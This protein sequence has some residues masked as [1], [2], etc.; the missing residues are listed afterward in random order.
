[1]RNGGLVCLMRDEG[2]P[3]EAVAV[4]KAWKQD[5]DR[6]LRME[7]MVEG[8]L[9]RHYEWRRGNWAKDVAARHR[10]VRIE[11]MNQQEMWGAKKVKEIPAL[12]A[13][14]ERRRLAAC[15]SLL[16]MIRHAVSKARGELA[17]V[18]AAHTTDTCSVCDTHFEAGPGI[19]GRCERGHEMDQDWNAARNICARRAEA[20]AEAAVA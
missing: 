2:T 5:N 9:R 15:G 7:R 19:M 8:H 12:K 1:M 4:L 18:E 6:Y 14:A 13:S 10:T 3:A 11:K 16:G 17:E 20:T